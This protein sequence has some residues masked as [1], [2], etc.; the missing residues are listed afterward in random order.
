MANCS[1]C[2]ATMARFENPDREICPN[3]PHTNKPTGDN[4]QGRIRDGVKRRVDDDKRK[5]TNRGKKR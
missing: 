2:G 5:D 1:T 4:G 3:E